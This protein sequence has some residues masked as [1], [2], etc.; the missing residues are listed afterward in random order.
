MEEA[1]ACLGGRDGGGELCLASQCCFEG[2][3]GGP[4]ALV[5]RS[6]QRVHNQWRLSLPHIF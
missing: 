4:I 3:S 5:A 1:V 6:C 2:S